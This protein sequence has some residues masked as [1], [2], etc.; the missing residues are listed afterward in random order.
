MDILFIGGT[1]FVGR[2]MVET[3]NTRGHTCSLFHRG[4]SGADLFPESEH[5]LGD[6]EQDLSALSGRTW[7]A[8][9]DVSGY[10]PSVVRESAKA[11]KG[12]VGRYV[13]ISTLSVFT[14][15][16]ESEIVETSPVHKMPGDWDGDETVTPD[17]YGALKVQCEKE[18]TDVFGAKSL[19]FRPGLVVGPHDVTDRFTYWVR[20]GA[21]ADQISVPTVADQP[22]QFTDARDLAKFLIDLVELNWN[23]TV[24]V[25]GP[26]KPMTFGEMWQGIQDAHGRSIQTAWDT[27][28]PAPM[29]CAKDAGR[30]FSFSSATA[31]SL[32]FSTRPL[33]Q[34]VLDTW[35]WDE[36]RGLPELTSAP[37]RFKQAEPAS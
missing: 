5:I 2:A 19:I 25:T 3:A 33:A 9:V 27:D 1:R 17:T 23:G 28:G 22:V 10:K 6:R 8:V 11:L 34:T 14:G 21:Q 35:A 31:K 7:D 20:A 29:P 18:V 32:G 36:E 37:S 12:S 13:F 24:N 30:F 16:G 4:V 15:V 26:Q